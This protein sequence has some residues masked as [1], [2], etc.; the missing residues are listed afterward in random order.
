[1][2]YLEAR[3]SVL[4]QKSSVKVVNQNLKPRGPGEVRGCWTGTK[5]FYLSVRSV[6]LFV[7]RAGLASCKA[8]IC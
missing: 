6:L 1:M 3:G 2:V 4:K 5:E 7:S 8:E